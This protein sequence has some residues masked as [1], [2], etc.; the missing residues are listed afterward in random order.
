MRKDPHDTCKE[1]EDELKARV[2][3]LEDELSQMQ[4]DCAVCMVCQQ[5][6]IP[7]MPRRQYNSTVRK[8][9]Y[10]VL[11][12][13]CPVDHAAEIV[14]YVAEQFTGKPI[15][16][17][18]H[19]TTVARMAREMGVLS[20]IQAG[21]ALT[22]NSK[23]S[24]A[25]DA[26][27]LD[28]AHVNEV[29]VATPSTSKNR[30]YVT[31]SVAQLPGGTTSDYTE[32]ITQ[33]LDDAAHAYS[34]W[35][36]EQPSDVLSQ[37][38]SNITSCISDRVAVNHCVAE[39]L[40]EN[41]NSQIVELHCNLHPLDSLANVS[42]T[43]LKAT[44]VAGSTYGKDCAAVNFIQGMSKMRYKSGKGDPAS[45]KAF[46]KERNIALKL[47]P[48]YV[49]NRLHILFHLAGIYTHLQKDMLLFLTK[50][51]PTRG[52]LTSALVKDLQN[53]TI[54]AHLQ[55]LGLFGKLLTGPW[56]SMFYSEERSS[57]DMVPH[58]KQCVASL[59]DLEKAPETLVTRTVDIFGQSLDS[60]DAVLSAVRDA[61]D[62]DES[63]VKSLCSAFLAVC[64]RQLRNYL[65]DDFTA[66]QREL[67]KIAPTHNMQ[68]ERIMAMSDS[69]VH[70]V[71]PARMDY[72]G[73]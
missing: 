52:G 65:A 32:H 11:S 4:M 53:P 48:R 3:F 34:G 46:C 38:K 61:P 28:G 9:I 30:D 16:S 18:P 17:L 39:T 66:Q 40:K 59:E 69:Q 20:D 71:P 6:V 55:I 21:E 8:C 41:V 24:I 14:G 31:L 45:F 15:E 37:I 68:S 64:K 35:A 44:G 7:T 72:V 43:A 49:G 70:R 36:G 56:M 19:P 1:T 13:Q 47:F 63:V 57:L 33:S 67:A 22:S 10:H 50:F 60:P 2:S 54:L 23:C 51:C 25:W 42:R 62:V 5:S 73:V 26:T 29:H 12:H 27:E 58:L